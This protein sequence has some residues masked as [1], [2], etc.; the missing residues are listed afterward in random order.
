MQLTQASLTHH[1]TELSTLRQ[2]T[3]T[4]SDSLRALLERLNTTPLVATATPAA[5]LPP[6]VQP[7][8]PG[9]PTAQGAPRA[10]LPQPAIPDAYDGNRVTGEQFLQSC[11]TYIQL[12]R[13][14]FVSDDLKI[15]WVLS[16]MKSGRAA[17]Y[18]LQV[19]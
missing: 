17:T 3:K 4:I 14:D 15:A 1:T 16:Y 11:F 6:A 12:C 18:A 8:A 5:E 9:P 19:F 7:P 2:T 13:D 10:L